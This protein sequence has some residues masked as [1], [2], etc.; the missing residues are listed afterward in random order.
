MIRAV[1][2]FDEGVP[3]DVQAKCL[4]DFER[5]LRLWSGLDVRVFKDRMGDDSKLRV[6]T[7][8]RR[9]VVQKGSAMGKTT[10]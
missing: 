8:A 3:D 9:L 10:K 6:V 5:A 7:D 2:R 1:V 4:F